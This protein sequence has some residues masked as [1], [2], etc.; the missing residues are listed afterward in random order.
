MSLR[1]PSLILALAIA[2]LVGI[3][4]A[5]ALYATRL[6]SL[7]IK[8]TAAGGELVVESL[9]G[10]GGSDGPAV[11]LPA[12]LTAVSRPDRTSTIKV[13]ARA[14]LVRRPEA[15]ISPSDLATQDRLRA[16][17]SSGTVRLWL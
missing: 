12:R 4:G 8:L 11:G 10:S 17:A 6:P 16:V 1:R 7:G 14:D 13:S 5:V 2:A 9:S 15:E 3:V